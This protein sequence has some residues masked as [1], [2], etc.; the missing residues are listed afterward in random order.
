MHNHQHD[1]HHQGRSLLLAVG[2]NLGFAL[3]EV[4]SGFFANSLVLLAGALHDAGDAV[5]LGLS[6]LGWRLSLLSPNP[7]RTFGY[8]KVRILV[9]FVNALGL[10][11]FTVFV[12][13]AAVL[14]IIQPE[15][16]KSPVL[17][18]M[19]VLGVVINGVG[20]G[21]LSRYRRSLNIRMAMWHLLDDLLGFIAVLVGGVLIQFTGWWIV[22][23][24][25]SVGIA[26]LVL[27]GTW[28]VFRQSVSIL[29]DSTPRDL[30]FDDVQGFIRDF[31]PVIQGVHD[32][33]IWTMGEGERAL[34][35]H[36]VVDDAPVSSYHSLL[37]QL[38]C[39]LKERFGITHVTLE[40]ECGGCKSGANV[41]LP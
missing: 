19:A 8:R 31:S 11:A 2:L 32:L 17:M 4:V 38:E 9:A 35:A 25:L 12:L 39:S 18:G 1:Y 13:R 29:I 37:A 20:V 23:P 15:P 40:L 41:C 10:G 24:L 14:R 3:A 30:S 5:A 22:D 7:R 21:V 34:M 28:R 16:V 27:Y 33:H 6:Y 36:L 26:G